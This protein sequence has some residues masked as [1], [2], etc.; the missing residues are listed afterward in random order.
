MVYKRFVIYYFVAM[1]LCIAKISVKNK[2][3]KE[4]EF[5]M[6]FCVFSELGNKNFCTTVLQ[7]LW[8]HTALKRLRQVMEGISFIESTRSVARAFLGRRLKWERKLN[9]GN[10][11]RKYGKKR[12]Y[13]GNFLPTQ[14]W[15]SLSEILGHNFIIDYITLHYIT[16]M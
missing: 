1:I 14:G 9:W 7:V 8:Y 16:L 4:K 12:K 10:I 6:W 5:G 3:V 11:K 2:C 13:S 15:V